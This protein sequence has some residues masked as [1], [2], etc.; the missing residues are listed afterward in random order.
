MSYDTSKTQG[1]VL[2]IPFG[3]PEA[4]IPAGGV[5]Q[6]AVVALQAG[7]TLRCRWLGITLLRAVTTS[8]IVKLNPSLGS[9]YA[10]LYGSEAT[11]AGQAPGFPLQLAQALAPGEG[12]VDGA[13]FGRVLANPDVYTI[14]AVNNLTCP[15]FVTVCGNFQLTLAS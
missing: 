1:R 14:L 12:N 5:I 2:G 7:Q 9:T 11:Q 6:A 10:G 13:A 8:P 4:Y 15:V 3:L